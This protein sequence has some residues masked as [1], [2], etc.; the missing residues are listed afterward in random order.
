MQ[1]VNISAYMKRLFLSTLCITFLLLW[2]TMFLTPSKTFAE[3]WAVMDGSIPTT[4]PYPEHLSDEQID[5]KKDK[6][7][8]FTY[9]II[10]NGKTI[11]S[12]NNTN[13]F[14]FEPGDQIRFYLVIMPDQ[15][16][17]IGHNLGFWALY[18][19]EIKN[20]D[21]AVR[22]GAT[23]N[24]GESTGYYALIKPEV[25]L[26]GKPFQ[27]YW[28]G[29]M[30]RPFTPD[31]DG[32]FPWRLRIR[33]PEMFP[34][35]VDYRQ[36]F[37]YR[38]TVP[39]GAIAIGRFWTMSSI[40]GSWAGT[41]YIF[42]SGIARSYAQFHY[43]DDLAYRKLNNIEMA[44]SKDISLT[45]PERSEKDGAFSLVPFQRLNLA[46]IIEEDSEVDLSH[47]IGNL[48]SATPTVTGAYW[49]SDTELPIVLP[50]NADANLLSNSLIA[51]MPLKST[52]FYI[53]D[54]N[55]VKRPTL[56]ELIRWFPG[57]IY[58]ATDLDLPK[59]PVNQPR[60]EGDN[61]RLTSAFD[62]NRPL[63]TNERL[64]HDYPVDPTTIDGGYLS[65]RHYYL[66]YRAIPAPIV[67]HKKDHQNN[68]LTGAHFS[69]FVKDD[70]GNEHCIA[71]DLITDG[72][73]NI[74]G[75]APEFSSYSYLEHLVRTQNPEQ[76]HLY[77]VN[78]DGGEALYLVP[79]TYILRE[80]QAP[81]GFARAADVTFEIPLQTDASVAPY[82]MT[83]YNYPEEPSASEQIPPYNTTDK[84]PQITQ[85]NPS[86]SQR[87]PLAGTP[88]EL[89]MIN[90]AIFGTG[91]VAISL[92]GIRK[93]I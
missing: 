42:W 23:Q 22:I 43:V 76:Y 67:I 48:N 59:G 72:E 24:P 18:P 17:R 84:Q 31:E 91:M 26:N 87:L 33:D 11:L 71:T 30:Y 7:I 82:F 90:V 39:E 83:V 5:K 73:G 65:L 38:F 4:N 88:S 12:G 13:Q 93:R 44:Q 34:N 74:G 37:E 56:S 81:S 25:Y 36:Y 52:D 9:E 77:R 15:Y 85:K 32:Y 75:K 86:Q 57:W 41:T 45:L 20:S 1:P 51:R 60:I 54:E 63:A 64:P 80:T 58:I 8:V 89:L 79:G 27:P 10:R 28:D 69:L 55:S 53:T 21:G 46:S 66:T 62:P 61:S 29:G 35:H 92:R 78:I 50:E 2:S 19:H 3:D 40:G 49:P 47:H 68:P 6:Q 70:Q 14:C 16:G